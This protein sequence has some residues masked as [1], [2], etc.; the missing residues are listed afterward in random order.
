MRACMDDE[1][2]RKEEN[3]PAYGGEPTKEVDITQ[4]RVLFDHVEWMVS[5]YVLCC[6]VD[7]RLLWEKKKGEKDK[8]G[9]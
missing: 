7:V 2:K 9:C 8:G 3:L 4:K 5:L 6:V 1:E